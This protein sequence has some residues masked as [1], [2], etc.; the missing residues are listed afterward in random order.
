LKISTLAIGFALISVFNAEAYFADENSPKSNRIMWG[1][2]I[3]DPLGLGL[4]FQRK[5]VGNVSA[6]GSIGFFPLDG[7]HG[8]AGVNY[9]WRDNER[10]RP[11]ASTS[12]SYL[13]GIGPLPGKVLLNGEESKFEIDHGTFLHLFGGFQFRLWKGLGIQYHLG[14]RQVLTGGGYE[15]ISSTD[16]EVAKDALDSMTG[17]GIMFGARGF[18]E[19]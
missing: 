2:G 1:G 11:F 12:L 8:S 7:F 10:F 18:W 17:S 3:R 6:S 5:F 16:P 13:G 14:W 15:L 19:L 4:E 9:L